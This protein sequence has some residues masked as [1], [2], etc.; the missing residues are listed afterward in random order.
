MHSPV[1]GELPA[2]TVEKARAFSRQAANL[3]LQIENDSIQPGI[4]T[5]SIRGLRP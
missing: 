5:V 1:R 4:L 3:S 2:K